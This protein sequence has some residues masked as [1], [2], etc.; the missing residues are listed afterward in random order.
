MIPTL[1]GA[2]LIGGFLAW[3]KGQATPV[4]VPVSGQGTKTLG[5]EALWA[6][7]NA[8]GYADRLW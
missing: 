6:V 1:I 5:A 4:G 8:R 3:V 2:V 7:P